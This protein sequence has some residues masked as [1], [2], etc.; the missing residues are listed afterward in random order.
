MNRDAILA[1]LIGF[2]LGLFITGILI[3]GPVL[4]KSVKIPQI[5][6]PKFP[7]IPSTTNPTA[8]PTVSELSKDL[9][10]TI[11]SPLADTVVNKDELLVSGSTLPDLLTVIA[12]PNNEDITNSG[13]DGKYVGKINLN[14]GK[15]EI[16]VT[17]YTKEKSMIKSLVIFYT[18]EEF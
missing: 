15:N 4:G 10:V 13:K 5:T 8:T 9:T 17:V 16:T 6:L 14:E 3:V 2:G 1:T 12:G 18:P 11:D 7:Q